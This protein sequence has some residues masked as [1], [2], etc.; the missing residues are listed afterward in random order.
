MTDKYINMR[1]RAAGV[2]YVFLLFLVGMAASGYLIL[3]YNDAAGVLNQKKNTLTQQNRLSDFRWMQAKYLLRCDSLA[4]Q[5]ERFNPSIKASYEENDINLMI[6]DLASVYQQNRWDL[7]YRSFYQLACLYE[8]WM[9]DK[10]LAWSK[11]E[12]INNF[13]VNIE[14]CEIGLQKKQDALKTAIAK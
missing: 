1:E 3:R 12:N 11:T 4:G 2:F 6:G 14:A 5:I 8:M 13:K 10:K 9:K 7:R